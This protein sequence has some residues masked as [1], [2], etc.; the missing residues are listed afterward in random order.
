MSIETYY[1]T[2][3]LIDNIKISRQ[4]L[5]KWK[6]NKKLV[7]VKIGNKNLYRESDVKRLLGETQPEN[8]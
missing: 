3:N 8:K 7:P 1:T 6:K 5:W 2:K 4:T